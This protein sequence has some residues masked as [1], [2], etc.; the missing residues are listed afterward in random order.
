MFET[1]WN[2]IFPLEVIGI[3]FNLISVSFWTVPD[4]K[5]PQSRL[6]MF[7]LDQMWTIQEL[8]VRKNQFPGH[9][10]V[11]MMKID[12]CGPNFLGPV[13]KNFDYCNGLFF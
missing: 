6:E 13:L 11:K 10:I 4:Q 5:I 3:A 12:Y 2:Q 8:P 7:S 1:E 9:K